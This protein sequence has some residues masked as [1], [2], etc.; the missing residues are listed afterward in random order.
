MK[1]KLGILLSICMVAVLAS[2]G[3]KSNKQGSDDVFKPSY[4]TQ[5]EC[6]LTVVGDYKNFEALVAEFDR[7]KEYYPNVELTYEYL[8]DYKNILSTALD[9]TNKPNIFFSYTWMMGNSKYDAVIEHME[10]LSNPS[11]KINLD[12]I[13]PG[14]LNRGEN[15]SVS[16]VPVFS[17]TY[18]ALVNDN[19][20]KKENIKYPTK[21]SELLTAC[22]A[23]RNKGYG[24]PMMGYS[25]KSSSSL[26]NTVAYPM[27]VAELAKDPA[28]LALANNL[29][30]AAGEYMRKALTAVDGLVKNNCVNLTECDKIADNYDKVILRFFEGDVP[31]MI[32]AGD[33]VSGTKK[34]ESQS[35]AFVNSPFDYSFHPIP[36]T[37]QG[38]YFIDSPSVEFSVNKNCENL[39]MTNEFMRFLVSDTELNQMAS[40]KRLVTPTKAMSLDPVYAPFGSVPSE[41]T[42]SPEVLG[43]K[44]ALATQIRQAAFKVG[45]GE[46]SI[47]EA[48]D[49]Y[50]QLS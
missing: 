48:I 25:A 2:C 31:M 16:M 41:R 38:G 30:P 42:F 1:R 28:A 14:L 32:C 26:M 35:E 7:F 6:S 33:T 45:K 37:E 44:D 3:K 36:V 29:D 50:G 39:D 17:R 43:V 11:L 9:R 13:R 21:W 8:D 20:F 4:D 46:L 23:L 22:E 10:N 5:T 34:R 18:G 24:S 47:Q 12:C 40:L 19:L 15:G 49:L 27:F